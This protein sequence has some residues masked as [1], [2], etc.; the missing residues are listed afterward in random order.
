MRQTIRLPA[1]L[2]RTRYLRTVP[3]LRRSRTTGP[4]ITRV[5]A[6]KGF[7]YRDERGRL[8]RDPE[9]KKRIESLAIPP[10]WKQVW[11]C[12]Y[13]NGHV[14]AVGIDAAGR[15]QYRYHQLWRE[16]KDQVK[17]ERALKLD[18]R[19]PAARRQV[20]KS[21]RLEGFQR[22]RILAAAFRLLDTGSLRVGSERY[23]TDNGS[24]GLSTLLC[25]HVAVKGDT[26]Q[27]RFPA[28]SG[29]E[30]DSDIT[31][32]DLAPLV[33]NLKRRGP[34]ARLLAW[35]DDDGEWHPLTAE[36]INDYVRERTGGDF[37]AKDFRTFHGTLAAAISLAKQ[38]PAETNTARSKALA[39]AMRDAAEELG[40]TPAIAK[41]SYVDPRIVERFEEGE[42]IDPKRL[43]AAESELRSL[44]E[45]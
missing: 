44:L 34:N 41:S 25:A 36:E 10:A 45:E 39:Q 24:F 22:E 27:L 31:D 28:K 37:T 14:Q 18:E 33:R 42:T 15:K 21:L 30:W 4:G 17:Y 12:P 9:L 2:W 5:R 38:G 16:Q 11:I 20:T 13:E 35:K 29:K 7:A 40:N 3:R 6:G 32:P 26:V 23:A 1:A 19:L 43:H 8:I